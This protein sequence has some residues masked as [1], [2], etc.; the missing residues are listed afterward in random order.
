MSSADLGGIDPPELDSAL[1]PAPTPHLPQPTKLNDAVYEL[2]KP[3]SAACNLDIVF[4]HGL[5]LQDYSTAYTETWVSA[6]ADECWPQ[7]WL[8]HDFPQAR[9]LSVSYDSSAIR[10]SKQGNRD[11]EATGESLLDCL[12]C[13]A[14]VGQ[15]NPVVLVGHSLGGLVIKQVCLKAETIYNSKPTADALHRFLINMRGVFFYATPHHGSRL[16][17]MAAYLPW[18]PSALLKYLTFLNKETESLNDSFCELRS[19]Y[20]WKAY[21]L[22]EAR[23]IFVPGLSRGLIVVPEESARCDM[24]YFAQL[25]EDHVTICKPK[26]KSSSSYRHLIS[27]ILSI[28]GKVHLCEGVP[29]YAAGLHSQ[30]ENVK[31]L[32]EESPLVAIVGAGGIGKTTIAK[33]VFNTISFDFEF[34]CFIDSAKSCSTNEKLETEILSNLYQY[35]RKLRNCKGDWSILKGKRVLLVMDDVNS[36]EQLS[37]VFD[38]GWF[39]QESRVIITAQDLDKLRVLEF[40]IYW[41]RN[42]NEQ[43]SKKLFC[44]HA[45]NQPN[46][47]PQFTNFKGLAQQVVEKCNGLPLALEVIGRSL[48]RTKDEEYTDE[49]WKECIT[50]LYDVESLQ[51]SSKNM[52]LRKLMVSYESLASPEKSMLVDVASLFYGWPINKIHAAWST[53]WKNSES[54]WSNLVARGLVS[55]RRLPGLSLETVYTHELLRDLGKNIA[56][57]SQSRI[58]NSL[59]ED[60]VPKLLEELKEHLQVK[61]LMLNRWRKEW[62]SNLD[63]NILT[64]MPNLRFLILKNTPVSGSCDSL[65]KGLCLLQWRITGS[66]TLELTRLS[67]LHKLAVLE[68]DARALMSIQNLDAMAESLGSLSEL[69]ILKFEGDF[70]QLPDDFGNLQ[71]LQHMS[72]SS[73]SRF[74]RL[75]DSFGRLTSLQELYI[76]NTGLV[77]LPDS[78]GLLSTLKKLRLECFRL[79]ALPESFGQLASLET[80]H[81]FC[82]EEIQNLPESFGHLAGL[83]FLEINVCPKLEEL[84]KSFGMLGALRKLRIAYCNSLNWTS[85]LGPLHSLVKL[86]ISGVNSLPDSLGELLSLEK[87]RLSDIDAKS[88]P[89]SFG[90]LRSLHLL[91]I[92]RCQFISGWHLD[93][94]EKGWLGFHQRVVKDTESSML[95]VFVYL[96]RGHQGLED[97]KLEQIANRVITKYF[98]YPSRWAWPKALEIGSVFRTS[99]LGLYYGRSISDKMRA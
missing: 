7:T 70:Q 1:P 56:L 66:S 11:M 12:V 14:G 31:Q 10:G 84:P 78:F 18:Y 52:V 88:L 64:R 51:G 55:Q 91:R 29:L 62:G 19:K 9:I 60:Q 15:T 83:Q 5:Q 49:A 96:R 39:T 82:C 27:F 95:D 34:T 13:Q 57:K 50:R 16:A 81:L 8:A 17:S 63:V 47:P 85:T 33:A 32:L 99:E 97:D 38:T 35:G 45:F 2:Y 65:P 61:G 59:H 98:P 6:K 42:L 86:E 92:Q 23:E 89:E 74:T 48:Y 53:C 30:A 46:I 44:H 25:G 37:L 21:G 28:V 76:S 87:L 36:R 4:F 68:L 58:S 24:D 94:Q 71:H 20:K 40:S 41:A 93:L 77:L 69:R 26:G 67:H 3:S 75:P 90:K 73:G 79:I 22:G 43:A 54:F 80:L 72:L